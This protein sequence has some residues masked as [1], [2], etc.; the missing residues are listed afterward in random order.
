MPMF[1]FDGRSV[2]F[3]ERGEGAPLVLVHAS[4]PVGHA[5]WFKVASL[6]EGEFRLVMPDLLAFGDSDDW[7][8]ASPLGHDIQ[9]AL[10][11]ELIDARVGQPVHLVG[12]SYGGASAIA[13]ALQAENGGEK[14]FH[15]SGGMIPLRAAQ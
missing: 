6:L 8:D 13:A 15:G 3:A 9:G 7:T 14:V 5:L 2:H 11:N 12:H 4:A 10:L 1:N